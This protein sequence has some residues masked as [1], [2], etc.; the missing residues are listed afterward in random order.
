MEN[1]DQPA[2]PTQNSNSASGE[3]VGGLTKREYIAAMAMQGILA[4]LNCEQNGGNGIYHVN[5]GWVDIN[6]VS[7]EAISCADEL[8]NQLSK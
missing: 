4:S 2:F 5:D 3:L 7:K 1:K 8:L 6:R